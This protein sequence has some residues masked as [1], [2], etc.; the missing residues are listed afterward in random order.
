MSAKKISRI[1]C[2]LEQNFG[3]VVHSPEEKEQ[4]RQTAAANNL[5][6]PRIVVRPLVP[7]FAATQEDPH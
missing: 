5:P 7:F 4:L 6:M 1:R 3:L 2:A